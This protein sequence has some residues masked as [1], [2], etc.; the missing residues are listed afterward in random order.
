MDN[1][2]KLEPSLV[3]LYFDEIT[4]IPRGSGNEKNIAKY[5][6]NF[7]KER[8]LE[9]YTDSINNVII[10]KEAS[11]NYKKEPSI[12]LQAHMDMVC[13]SRNGKFDFLK[14]AI[15]YKI[16][17]DFIVAEETTLGA[18]NGIGVAMI[19]AILDMDIDSPKI[20]ALF[21]VNEENG[22]TGAR[23]LDGSLLESKMLINIDS[24][25]E[26]VAC[27]SCSGGQ[28][29]KIVLEKKFETINSNKL[30]YELS[31]TGLKGGHSGSDIN[32]GLANANKLLGKA[33]LMIRDKIDVDLID[34]EG[35]KMPNAIPRYA[36]AIIAI[37][38]ENKVLIQ[39]L[40]VEIN[41][42]LMSIYSSTDV[43]LRVN[44]DIIKEN[45]DT[46]LSNKLRDDL[47]YILNIIHTGVYRMSA[48]IDG[49]VELSLNL[50]IIKSLEDN[51]EIHTNIRSSKDELVNECSRVIKLISEN[52][53]YEFIVNSQ[54]PAWDYL[55]N[56]K[57][58]EIVKK[59]YLKTANN[60]LKTEAIHAGLECGLF[61][62]TIGDIDMISIGPN[63][64]GVHSPGEKVQISSVK[65]VFDFL[66][67]ILKNIKF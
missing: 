5:L 32:K 6:I 7:A 8:N 9:V 59:A 65:R 25:E 58:L 23:N 60:D 2:K 64:Y 33:L 67:D 47:I 35:G 50:G 17:D 36:K 49:L 19:M 27:I 26:G 57:L 41:K 53:G 16:E 22:M 55:E 63:I 10:K 11:E 24:E 44:F 4:K 51:F 39:D 40:I 54:Y 48:K 28:K 46:K 42:N 66:L 43:D 3:F 29:N 13:E 1:I 14:D 56:S 30:F 21:T 45:Y 38:K 34:I 52:L 62:K 31:V 61:K 37:D 15:N 12:I 18:D 20:E